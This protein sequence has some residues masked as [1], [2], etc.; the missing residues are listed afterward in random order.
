[1]NADGGCDVFIYSYWRTRWKCNTT[2]AGV[3]LSGKAIGFPTV[4]ITSIVMSLNDH[5]SS[6]T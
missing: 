3:L 1:M 2:F 5:F 4:Y 6:G